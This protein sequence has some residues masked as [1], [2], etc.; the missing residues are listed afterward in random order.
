M[1]RH[2]SSRRTGCVG[3]DQKIKEQLTANLSM[4]GIIHVITLLVH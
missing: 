3:S 2:N 4:G 1:K